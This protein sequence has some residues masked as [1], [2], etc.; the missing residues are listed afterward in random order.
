[1]QYHIHVDY[2]GARVDSGAAIEQ[3]RRSVAVCRG[4]KVKYFILRVVCGE[5]YD[6]LYL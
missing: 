3:F 4:H 1:M 5:N 2:A 6:R